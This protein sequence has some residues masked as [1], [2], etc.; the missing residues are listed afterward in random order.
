MGRF[1]IIETRAH[2]VDGSVGHFQTTIKV[3]FRIANS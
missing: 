3:G 2:I 1:L